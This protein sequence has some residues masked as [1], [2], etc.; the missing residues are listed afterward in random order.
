MSAGDRNGLAGLSAA[1]TAG[2]TQTGI[3]TGFGVG[4]ADWL[5]NEMV[6]DVTY[7]VITDVR[8][9]VRVKGKVTQ[10]TSANLSQGKETNTKQVYEQTTNWLRH[11]TRIASVADKV[12]LKFK[13]A[14][15][16]LVQQVSDQIAGIFE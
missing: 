16:V 5:A 7:S 8:V 13:E 6:K 11:T 2:N 15:P 1:M 3:N 4:A 9:S 10:K 14:K 12:N